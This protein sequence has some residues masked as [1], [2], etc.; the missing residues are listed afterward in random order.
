MGDFGIVGTQIFEGDTLAQAGEFEVTA[1]LKSILID[2]KMGVSGIHLDDARIIILS[3][4]DGQAN[5]DIT[6]ATAE[7]T[8]TKSD[9][10]IDFNI[11]QFSI[12]NSE[13]AYVD[14]SSEIITQIT[15]INLKGTGDLTSDIFDLTTAGEIGDVNLSYGGV[16]YVSNKR[17]EMEMVLAMDLN[18]STYTFKE[19]VFNI[20]DFP[21]EIN[22]AFSMLE[23]GYGMDLNFFSPSSDFKALYSLIPGVYT[24]MFDDIKREGSLSFDGKLNGN[25]TEETMPGFEFNLKVDNG[26]VQYPELTESL[27]NI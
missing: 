15:G 7:E 8:P 24:A 1:N 9:E 3:L 23:E 22:G 18:N 17:L 11:S 6:K 10:G 4:A 19:N 26:K 5:Y 21:L 2:K 14:L 27:Q 13:L 16:Q 12:S 20:N 25:Y